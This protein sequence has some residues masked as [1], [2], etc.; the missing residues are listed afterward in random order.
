MA[1]FDKN[2]ILRFIK[3]F[4]GESINPKRD[5]VI[6]LIAFVFLIICFA[7]L[8]F[9]IYKVTSSRELFIDISKEEI[10]VDKVKTEEMKSAVSKFEERQMQFNSLKPVRLI[11]PSI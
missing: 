11:D 3:V 7:I 10:V 2:K 4:W 6:L 5:W 9:R 8:N 1:T